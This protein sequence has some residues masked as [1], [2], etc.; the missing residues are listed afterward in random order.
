MF[1]FFNL[2]LSCQKTDLANERN[3]Q[4]CLLMPN[5][6]EEISIKICKRNALCES[7][8]F[9]A[10]IRHIASFG[11]ATHLGNSDGFYSQDSNKAI[12]INLTIY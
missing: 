7:A 9:V 4:I 11:Q 10:S 12:I 6:K 1:D 3:R 5:C 2:S 8:A